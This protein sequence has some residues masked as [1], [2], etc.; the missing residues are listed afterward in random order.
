[1]MILSIQLQEGM[2][3]KLSH[4]LIHTTTLTT[5]QVGLHSGQAT[6]IQREDQARFIETES[7]A[8]NFQVRKLL[9]F[10]ATSLIKP[11]FMDQ[12]KL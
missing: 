8:L 3:L 5:Y 4:K 1:M 10:I 9:T 6:S 11:T 2:E 7:Q 12:D